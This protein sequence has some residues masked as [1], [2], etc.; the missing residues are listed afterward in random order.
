MSHI[1][2]AVHALHA[3][4]PGE[5]P[6]D[7]N[8]VKLNT[9]ENPYP[10]SPRV[11]EAMQR[12]DADALRRY[13]DPHCGDLLH[14]IAVLHGVPEGSVFIGNGSD[15]VLAL[16]TRAFVEHGGRVGYFDTSYSLYPVLTEI[17]ESRRHPVELGTDFDWQMPAGYEAALFFLTNPNA[18]TGTRFPE[19]AVSSFCASFLGVVVID[20]AY[21]DFAERD[22]LALAAQLKN[23]LVV[24]TLSKSYSLAGIRLG[25]AI[26]H[27]VLIEALYKIKDSY[28]VNVLTQRIALAALRDRAYMLRN[29][30]QVKRTRERVGAQLAALGHRVWPSETNFLWV[31]PCGRG[32]K[33]VFEGLRRHGIVIRYFPGSKTGRCLRITVGTD[34]EMDRFLMGWQA[35][36][37]G[38]A[39]A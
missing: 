31:E 32:A 17:Q 35:G 7:R 22:C 6:R 11:I 24:R 28:N 19:E 1:R 3:Y 14:A 9:N 20:E 18:P 38:K 30:A 16:C 34:A 2:K 13:P 5:Q 27:P 33:E 37:D 8:V 21:V 26:G 15:E 25:Y 10:P 36:M 29:V 4:V 23:V 12:V 39:T